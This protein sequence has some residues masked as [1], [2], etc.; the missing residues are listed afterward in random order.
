LIRIN[1]NNCRAG[2]LIIVE[3]N[4]GP[5]GALESRGATIISNSEQAQNAAMALGIPQDSI[6]LLPGGA[7][8]TL[9]EAVTVRQYI[10]DSSAAD[11]L[12][13]V[14]SA[15]H[16][17]RAAMIFTA[18][19]SDTESPVI[20]FCSPSKYT[21]FEASAWWHGK[22]GIQAVLSEYIKIW[23]FVLVE[24]RGLRSRE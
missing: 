3:E 4:M 1:Y 8:S 5:F 11:T 2:R 15:H 16:T 12:L 14:T 7:R 13:I 20:I 24:R 21:G 19:F 23:S 22:E 6:T 18:A 10:H 9:D 17:R